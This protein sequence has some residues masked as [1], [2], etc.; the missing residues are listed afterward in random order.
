M[1]RISPYWPWITGFLLSVSLLSLLLA[2]YERIALHAPPYRD[3]QTLLFHCS[4]SGYLPPDQ[5]LGAYNKSLPQ[6]HERA[7]IRI[8]NRLKISGVLTLLT[9]SAYL[10]RKRTEEAVLGLRASR[11]FRFF[12]WVCLILLMLPGA[13]ATF[14]LAAEIHA[15]ATGG[16][17]QRILFALLSLVAIFLLASLSAAYSLYKLASSS[18]TGLTFLVLRISLSCFILLYGF[19]LYFYFRI[20][21]HIC[22]G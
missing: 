12:A 13:L 15:M 10:L 11:P 7:E 17:S 6:I 5:C 21:D 20:L 1:K 16:V 22:G 19:V 9:L 3:A 2:T 14:A 8:W 4:W 18:R